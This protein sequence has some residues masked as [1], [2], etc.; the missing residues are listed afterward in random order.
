MECC[1]FRLMT[2]EYDV[3]F[4]L[5]PK[6]KVSFRVILRAKKLITQIYDLFIYLCSMQRAS[7]HVYTLIINIKRLLLNCLS[8]RC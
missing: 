4:F 6:I 5:Q 1:E 8:T 7:V 3:K 2:G